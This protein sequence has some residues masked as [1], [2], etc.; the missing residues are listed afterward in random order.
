MN[1]SPVKV[2]SFLNE[3]ESSTQTGRGFRETSSTA[4]I[5]RLLFSLK[6]PALDKSHTKNNFRVQLSVGP[7]QLI[8]EDSFPFE[9][10]LQMSNDVAM[11]LE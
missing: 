6:Y 5:L 9:Y 4:T 3:E 1:F 11:T 8:P 7:Q 2:N 10:I